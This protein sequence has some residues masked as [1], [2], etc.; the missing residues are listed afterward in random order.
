MEKRVVF[1]GRWLPALLLLPQLAITVAFFFVPAG[2]ALYQSLFRQDAFGLSMVWVGLDNFRVLWED[3]AYLASFRTTAIFALGV[4]LL[5]LTAGLLLAWFAD[6]LLRATT[7]IR[8]LIIWPYAI[9]PAIA[10]VLWMF[11]FNPSLGLVSFWLKA[12]GV[13]WNYLLRS[14]Q[15]LLLVVL[16]AAWK[17]V[18]Y[19]FLFFL[20]GLQ[21]IPKSLIEAAA[22]D[23]AGV[24]RRFRSIVFPLLAPTTFFLLV[25]NMVYAFFDT[26]AIIDAVTQGGPFNSTEILVYK[27]YRDGFHG[28]DFGGSAAQSVILMVLVIGLTI[29]Q[30]RYVERKVNY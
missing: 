20:A 29:L 16:I 27:V 11:L 19:N 2:Q 1:Q 22:I 17:Q 18:S 3:P 9:A 23:G 25:I 28:L 24:W 15:A 13:N 30:F 5:G 26:F 4:T 6:R 12:L 14:D 10:G 21:S 8:T 7:L